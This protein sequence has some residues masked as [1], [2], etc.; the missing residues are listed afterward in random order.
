MV[1]RSCCFWACGRDSM[2]WWE[3]VEETKLLLTQYSGHRKQRKRK[4][5][6]PTFPPR[7]HQQHSEDFLRRPSFLKVPSPS[8]S[9]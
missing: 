4:D 2:L 9:V 6:G 5:E 1:D 8:S 7:A 3:T